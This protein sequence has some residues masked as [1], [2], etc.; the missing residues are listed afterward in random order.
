MPD[1]NPTGKPIPAPNLALKRLEKLVGTWDLK[2]RTLDSQNDNISGW[3]TFE[4]MLDGYFLKVE[5]EIDFKGFKIHSLEIIFYDPVSQTFPS[6]V[7]SNM[8]ENAYPY[9][10]DVDGNKVMHWMDTSRYTGTFNDDGKTLTGGWRPNDGTKGDDGS[11][12]DV[13]MTRVK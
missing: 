2:G 11:T 9:H 8:S 13:V 5:G 3:S 12:Y 4:W 6:H 7:Y 1:N 10:W